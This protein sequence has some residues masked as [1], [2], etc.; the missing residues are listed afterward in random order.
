MLPN[1]KVLITGEGSGGDF[2]A[3]AKIFDPA[4]NTFRQIANMTTRR[5]GHTAMRSNSALAD[6]D[7]AAHHFSSNRVTE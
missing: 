6:R 1:G 3:S 5:A 2:L 7:S 4:R